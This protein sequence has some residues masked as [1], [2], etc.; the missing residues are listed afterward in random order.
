MNAVALT[1]RQVRSENRTF[2]RNP[3]SAFFTFIFPL[4][5]MAIFSLIFGNESID[6]PG[7]STKGATFFVPAITAFSVITACYTNVAMTVTF[8]R[9]QGIL[10]RIRGTPLPALVFMAGKILNAILIA[11]LLVAIVV[12]YGVAFYGVDL[13]TNTLP[14]FLITLA[15]G[16]AAFCALGLAVTGFVPNAEAAPA[17]VNA[18]IF[19]LLFISDG[20]IRSDNAP[21]WL[22]TLADI[23]PVRH[24]SEALQ[25][26]FNPFETGS[27]FAWDRLAVLAAWGLLGIVIASRKFTWEPRR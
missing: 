5:F 15:V 25:T 7:G 10:K 6:V 18:T 2:W 21:G 3:A 11:L 26:A 19:P 12:G 27:G 14:A 16:S 22:N 17:V 13:P 1:L 23:F 9:D 24:F 8:A 20:F 4:M